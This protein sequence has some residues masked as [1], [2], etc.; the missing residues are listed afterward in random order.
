MLLALAVAVS[1]DSVCPISVASQSGICQG[2]MAMG[3]Q[4]AANAMH[5]DVQGRSLSAKHGMRS[6][7]G[8]FSFD[9]TGNSAERALMSESKRP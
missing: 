9:R 3:E 7:K 6:D 4:H 8:H 5:T 2:E 1:F